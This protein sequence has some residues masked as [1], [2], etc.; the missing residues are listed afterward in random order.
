MWALSRLEKEGKL[1]KRKYWSHYVFRAREQEG[2]F[3]TLFGRQKYKF[4]QIFYNRY[5]EI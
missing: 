2:E 4:F 1:E 3:H 5:F